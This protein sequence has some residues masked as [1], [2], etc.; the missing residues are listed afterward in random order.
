MCGVFS[1]SIQPPRGVL[2]SWAIHGREGKDTQASID[3][4]R[5]YTDDKRWG[6]R[7]AT[8]D[9][10][11]ASSS[12]SSS[13]GPAAVPTLLASTLH[14]RKGV[15]YFRGRSQHVGCQQKEAILYLPIGCAMTTWVRGRESGGTWICE[16]GKRCDPGHWER[17]SDDM[18][19]PPILAPIITFPGAG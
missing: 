2:K 8:E 14:A 5:A 10:F 7:N 9:G 16:T 4:T 3:K 11:L 6:R 12:A 19:S 18:P 13:V 15:P 17:A 1:C